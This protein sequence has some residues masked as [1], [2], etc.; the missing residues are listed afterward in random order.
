M[1]SGKSDTTT[2]K[3]LGSVIKSCRNILR[4]DKGLSTDVDRI[5]QLIWMMFLKF[6]D[7]M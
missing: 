2:D 6:I 1:S 7:D 3:R 4:K 5:P